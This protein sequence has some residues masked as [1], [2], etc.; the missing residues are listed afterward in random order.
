MDAL[1][2]RMTLPDG[3]FIKPLSS[4]TTIAINSHMDQLLVKVMKF[5]SALSRKS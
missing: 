3:E 4:A 1:R 2:A 5:P